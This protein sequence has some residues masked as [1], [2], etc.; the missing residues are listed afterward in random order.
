MEPYVEQVLAAVGH[1]EAFVTDESTLGD[2]MS[3]CDAEEKHQWLQR[4]A[5]LLDLG[6]VSPSEHIWQVAKRVMQGE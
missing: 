5:K 2:F 1:P 4:V 6:S 3:A